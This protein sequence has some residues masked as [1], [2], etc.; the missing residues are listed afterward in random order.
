[1]EAFA[2]LRDVVYLLYR[3]AQSRYTFH[4]FMKALALLR[5]VMYLLYRSTQP[6]IHISLCYG[7]SW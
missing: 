1:M 7:D 4:L 3:R 2:L 5:D 6:Q